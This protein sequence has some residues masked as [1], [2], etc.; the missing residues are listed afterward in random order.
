MMNILKWLRKHMYPDRR[1]EWEQ[2]GA[3]ECIY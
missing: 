2:L 1:H 3:C